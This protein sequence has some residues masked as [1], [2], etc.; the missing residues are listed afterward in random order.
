MKR[1]L[2]C[3]FCLVPF[4]LQSANPDSPVLNKV[5]VLPKAKG[6]VYEMLNLISE[7]SDMLFIYNDKTL[8]NNRKTKIKKGKTTLKQAI[9]DATQEPNLKM[10]VIDNHVLLYIEEEEEDEKESDILHSTY[11]TIEGEVKDQDT[12]EPLPFASV[13]LNES[14]IGTVANQNGH[15]A[16]K[17]PDSLKQNTVRISYVGYESKDIP[18]ELMTTGN[19][20][21]LLNI[22]I[23]SMQEVIVHIVNPLKVVNEM[24]EKRPENHPVKQS[25]FTAFYREGVD[26]KN[27]FVNL[28][29]AVFNI[30]KQP[31][32]SKRD[33]LVKLLK[34]RKI[35]NKNI[36]DSILLKLK[37]GINAS[38]NL[39]LMKNLPDFL[40]INEGNLYNYA[41]IDMT[42]IDSKPAHI[43]AFEQKPEIKEALYKGELYIDA[44]NSALLNVHFEINP[45]YIRKAKNRLVVKQ[46]KGIDITPKE[47]VYTVSYKKWDGKYYLYYIRGDLSF[48]ISK[49]SW[50]FNRSSAINSFFEMVIS[51]IE[52][53]NIK[54]FPK[55][56]S[57]PG[58]KIFSE[59]KYTYDSNFWGDFNIILPERKLSDEM[60]RISSKIEE[61]F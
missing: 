36:S 18:V 9:L 52:T 13:V 48:T 20:D 35:S 8:D 49:K 10:K 41:K 46:S 40:E 61:S 2:L 31:F 5:I 17:I 30:Y 14:T 27:G 47:A 59:T 19:M 56:E 29:E 12:F 45:K 7:S 32:T 22:R 4:C 54:P 16:L 53:G 55:D 11:L 57:L 44:E 33:D 15:F 26:Y 43:I 28:T 1:F 51:K 38:L 39:D 6:T 25:V 21:I 24:L 42:S 3:I 34:M 23:V 37:A 58:S 50:F 60:E